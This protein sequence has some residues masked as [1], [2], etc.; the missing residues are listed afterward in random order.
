MHSQL[1]T[2]EKNSSVSNLLYKR[3]NCTTGE[4]SCEHHMDFL[5]NFGPKPHWFREQDQN[6]VLRSSEKQSASFYVSEMTYTVSSGTLNSYCTMQRHVTFRTLYQFWIE[7]FATRGTALFRFFFDD[8]DFGLNLGFET[9]IEPRPITA[10]NCYVESKH[11]D[12]AKLRQDS[13]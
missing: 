12:S 7:T 4:Q 13:L 8:F 5:A 3:S 6:T 1:H 9:F 2:T 11:S 10:P